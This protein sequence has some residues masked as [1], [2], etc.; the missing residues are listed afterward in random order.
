MRRT[1]SIF[2][3]ALWPLLGHAAYNLNDVAITCSDALTVSTAAKLSVQCTG[4]LS[5][6]GKGGG[7]RL[8]ADESITLSATGNLSLSN[9]S[10]VSPQIALQ[11]TNGQLSL[12]PDVVLF[13]SFDTPIAPPVVTLVAG[14]VTLR[15]SMGNGTPGLV[16]TQDG[17]SLDLVGGT[18]LN[19][20]V[21]TPVSGSGTL[22]LNGGGA[23][24]TYQAPTLPT[25]Q[26]TTVAAPPV[27]TH[28]DLP[29]LSDASLPLAA[30]PEPTTTTLT[31]VGLIGLLAQLRRRRHKL[32]R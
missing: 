10:V 11:V 13:S 16:I 32:A 27:I 14:E 2:A 12:A 24:L 23:T 8:M 31:A 29:S 6:S 25:E 17:G 7:A 22:T 30:V 1:T 28:I 26:L 5:V 20:P 21:L 3:L 9:L 18:L 15:P 4:D 19:Q